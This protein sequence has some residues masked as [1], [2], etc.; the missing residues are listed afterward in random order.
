MGLPSGQQVREPASRPQAAGQVAVR[1][2]GAHLVMRLVDERPGPPDVQRAEQPGGLL[3]RPER[4]Q[5]RV[6]GQHA[7][8]HV[9]QLGGHRIDPELGDADQVDLER[10]TPLG[11]GAGPQAG[12]DVHRA[13]DLLQARAGALARVLVHLVPGR[14]ARRGSQQLDIEP[15]RG[16]AGLVADRSRHGDR[17][18]GPGRLRV[19]R[20]DDDR[21]PARPAAPAC[22]VPAC[23][24]AGLHRAGLAGAASASTAVTAAGMATAAARDRTRRETSAVSKPCTLGM[25]LPIEPD[26]CFADTLNARA[27]DQRTA[28]RGRRAAERARPRGRRHRPPVRAA[29]P[30]AGPGRRPGP[31][32]VPAASGPAIS[33]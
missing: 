3:P 18:A 8:G 9:N 16:L 10:N 23:G 30:R 32:R 27:H 28:E 5:R 17:G 29:R 12:H 14:E 24:L 15:G 6:R 2:R 20:V 7:P 19:H 22:A 1:Q 25:L 31:G 26:L 13:A 21:H 4:Q 33:T 11:G